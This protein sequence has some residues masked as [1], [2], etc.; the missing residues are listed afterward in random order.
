M[1]QEMKNWHKL[2]NIF[3]CLPSI[4]HQLYNII[5]TSTNISPFI[6]LVLL[7]IVDM[8]KL[9]GEKL[10]FSFFLHVYANHPT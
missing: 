2:D 7:I 8:P 3:F 1:F 4:D 6:F 10:T 5:W 9:M